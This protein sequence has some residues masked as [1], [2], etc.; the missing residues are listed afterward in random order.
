MAS[1][2]FTAFL[3]QIDTKAD[4]VLFCGA[5][6][7]GKVFFKQYKELGLKL[8]V[9]A[10]TVG[11]Q[12]TIPAG[13]INAWCWDA[14]V[15]TPASKRFVKAYESKHDGQSPATLV[16]SGYTTG[17]WL[18]KAIE[19]VK[20]NVENEEQFLQALKSVEL[21]DSPRGK[22]KLDEFGN[23]IENIYVFKFEENGNNVLIKTFPS[24]GQFWKFPPDKILSQPSYSRQY[25]A[26]SHCTAQ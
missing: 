20:G 12:G 15:P 7:A 13:T 23:P 6:G 25:P 11:C 18:Q 5:L 1:S 22:L 21:T 9:L 8:P 26:C 10:P 4:A 24:I 17:L 16:E 19:A 2:D 3:R 14:A